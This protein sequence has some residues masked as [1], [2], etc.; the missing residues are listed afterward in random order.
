[1]AGLLRYEVCMKLEFN[2]VKVFSELI[3]D[4]NTSNVRVSLYGIN[5]DNGAEEFTIHLYVDDVKNKTI[6]EIHEQ[7]EAE[8]L[9]RIDSYGK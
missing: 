8:L 6:K 2:S 1:M 4:P 9:A 3:S 5:K 7:A